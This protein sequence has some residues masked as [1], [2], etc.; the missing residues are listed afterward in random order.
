MC[1]NWGCFIIIYNCVS[2]TKEYKSKLCVDEM[3]C[4]IL[5]WMMIVGCTAG[6]RKDTGCRRA[7]DHHQIAWWHP[8]NSPLVLQLW[9]MPGGI[10]PHNNIICVLSFVKSTL[11][12][13]SPRECQMIFENPREAKRILGLSGQVVQQNNQ[14]VFGTTATNPIIAA[15]ET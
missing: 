9:F 13:E 11:S 8:P 2:L 3:I 6:G 15:A 7:S 1:L 14:D 10:K 12:S 5:G 4:K